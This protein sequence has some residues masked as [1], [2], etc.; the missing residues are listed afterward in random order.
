MSVQQA[1]Q[2]VNNMLARVKKGEGST[3]KVLSFLE[4]KCHILLS[5]LI[6]L[7]YIVLRKCSGKMVE[8]AHV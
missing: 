4:I 5:Y 1:T 2:F 8:G 7:T 6:N 3:D